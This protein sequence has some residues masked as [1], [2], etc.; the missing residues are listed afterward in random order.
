MKN[1]Y[2]VKI[3]KS[4]RPVLAESMS[5]LD[6]WVTSQGLKSWY[7]PGNETAAQYQQWRADAIEI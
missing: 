6:N 7:V 2:L 1:I 4:Y 5:Q 3:G